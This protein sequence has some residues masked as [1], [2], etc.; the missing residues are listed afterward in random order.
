MHK[1]HKIW[2]GIDIICLLSLPLLAM[3][4]SFALHANTFLSLILFYLPLLLYFSYRTRKAI[5]KTTIFAS[6][7]S[8]AFA[9]IF[10]YPAY[11][12]NAW[13]VPT[14]FPLRIYGK[15]AIEDIMWIFL[16]SYTIVI[17]YEHFVDKAKHTILEGKIKYGML[18]VIVLF[19]LFLLLYLLIPTL[20]VIHFYYFWL[21]MIFI[22][23]PVL[24]MLSYYRQLIS[25]FFITS[26]YF[27]AHSLLYEITA[28][29]LN[30]WSFPG[31]DYIGWVQ[32]FGVRLPFEEFFFFIVI[33]AMSILTYF[34]F[35]DVKKIK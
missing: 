23:L 8:F 9:F 29:K 16:F 6:L 31:T 24:A 32:L 10:D 20:L 7:L 1:T 12:D 26:S 15:V 5:L 18:L 35:F 17:F 4:I 21:G 25:G 13:Y 3:L 22:F 14:I 2:K 11:I 27:F 19:I 30:Q 34:E 33:A 28:L